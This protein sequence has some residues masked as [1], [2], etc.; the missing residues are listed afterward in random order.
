VEEDGGGG[1]G[2]TGGRGEVR[3]QQEREMGGAKECK[4]IM[5]IHSEVAKTHG[6]QRM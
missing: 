1:V 4:S 2:G 5:R 3:A 6:I